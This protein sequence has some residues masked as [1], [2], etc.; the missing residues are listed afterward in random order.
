MKLYGSENNEAILHEIGQRIKDTRIL[1]DLKQTELADKAGI[2]L[3][4]MIRIEKGTAVRSDHL[5]N[6]L[7]VLNCLQNVELLIPEQAARPSD[8]F[9]QKQK[10][11]RVK[12]SQKENRDD[13]WKWGDEE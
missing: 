13:V 5:L 1:S 9:E 12:T 10:R 4:T 3:A 6:V 7:R 2:S 11:K 8:Y